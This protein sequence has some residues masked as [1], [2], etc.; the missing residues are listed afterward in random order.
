MVFV[1]DNSGSMGGESMD[2]AKASLEQALRTLRPQDHFNVIRFDDFDDQIVRTAASRRHPTR[3][4]T[5]IQFARSLEAEGGTEMLPALKAALADAAATGGPGM[6]RQIIFLTDGD[7]SNEEEMAAAIA[8]DSGKSHV[9]P[10]RNWLGAEQLSNGAHGGDGGGT[11]TNIGNGSEVNS[12]MTALLDA[13]AGRRC[14][15]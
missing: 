2:E 10:R 1:I 5:A 3:S 8:A 9:F 6:L 12:K 4:R 11:Y 13:R 7:I 15:T 14:R